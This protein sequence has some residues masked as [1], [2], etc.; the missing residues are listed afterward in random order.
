ME[1]QSKWQRIRR[2]LPSWAISVVLH[3][4]VLAGLA[5]IT[6][7][8]VETRQRDRVLTLAGEELAG[9]RGD[10][11]QGGLRGGLE[12]MKPAPD[13]PSESAALSAAV[14]LPE[15]LDVSDLQLPIPQTLSAPVVGRA[16]PTRSLMKLLGEVSAREGLGKGQAPG[17]GEGF[18]GLISGLRKKG[19]DVVLVLD[20]TNSMAPYI[21]QAKKRLRKVVGV[22]TH[23]VEDSRFGVVA[24]KDYGDGY[25]P[26]AVKW[27]RISGDRDAAIK[28]IGDIVAGGGGDEP[29]PIQQALAVATN[30]RTMG[31]GPGRKR[32]I[33]LVGDSPVHASGREEAFR[34]ARKFA[35]SPYYGTINV[36]DTGGKDQQD[37]PRQSVRADLGRIAK[38]GG[39]SAFLL[40]DRRAFW[41]HL[42]VSVFGKRFEDDVNTII[43]VLVGR[44]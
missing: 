4:V 13:S 23:L 18:G 24:Y 28:F 35:Q 15:T 36:I 10:D 2:H 9:P 33:I 29:E 6:W 42:I 38:E 34:V 14:P 44:E 19:L 32:V 8:V 22:I 1:K 7:I 3:L 43:E 37:E 5:M 11:G 16:D 21:E 25:G 40:K 39:G 20:A 31:W 17:G 30:M 41:R 26:N 12:H 27:T